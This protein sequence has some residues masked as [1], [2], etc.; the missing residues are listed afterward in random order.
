MSFHGAVIVNRI[1]YLVLEAENTT[2]DTYNK[3]HKPGN[4]SEP[5]V[6]KKYDFFKWGHAY[7]L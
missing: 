1:L 3:H 4:K 6:A 5:A 2:G 7:N